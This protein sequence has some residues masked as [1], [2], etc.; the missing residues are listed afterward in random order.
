MHARFLHTVVS[1]K[2]LPAAFCGAMAIT[3]S[4]LWPIALSA[5]EADGDFEGEKTWTDKAGKSHEIKAPSP[6]DSK[7]RQAINKMATEGKVSAEGDEDVFENWAQH[8][9]RSLTWKENITGLPAARRELKKQLMRFGKAPVLDLHKRLNDLTLQDCTAVAKDA[10]YPRAV[11]IN[12]TLMLAELDEREYNAGTNQQA[13]V[14]PAAT[15]ALIELVADTKQPTFVRL[16]AEVAL[17][18]HTQF[19]MTPA[20]QTKT[21]EVLLQIMQTPIVEAK[22]MQG[23][24]WLRLRASDLLLAMM[25]SK[26][27]VAVDQAAMAT[28]LADLIDEDA[29]P[30]WARATFA[31]DLGHLDGKSLP[32]AKVG[33]TVRSLAGLMLAILQGSPFV[34]DE[35]AEDEPEKDTDKKDAAKKDTDKKDADKKDGDKDEKEPPAANEAISPTAQRLLSEEMMWQLA[36][37]RRALFGREAHTTKEPGPDPVHGL[38]AGANDADKADIKSV[39]KHIEE[40]VKSL[41]DVP[42]KLDNLADT[43]RSANQDLEALLSTPVSEEATAQADKE[44]AE[45]GK[46]GATRTGPPSGNAPAGASAVN[47]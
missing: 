6:K 33:A 25:E 12:C 26:P 10:R 4:M 13:V 9:V 40:V 28:A 1:G 43:L 36:R 32:P 39:V 15:S 29:L 27:P 2:M 18:R 17:M 23:Q 24:A 38:Y 21:V 34:P 14:L 31:G 20:L 47:K 16:P 11:R 3:L 5:Q 7:S 30:T 41:A 37:I 42:D 22:D 35:T 46:T 8:L 45:A 19:G 44:G